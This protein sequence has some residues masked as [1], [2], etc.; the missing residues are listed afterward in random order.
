M[1]DTI[2]F[3]LFALSD[4]RIIGPL[5]MTRAGAR[6]ETLYLDENH[7][8][9]HASTPDGTLEIIPFEEASLPAAGQIV[10]TGRDMTQWIR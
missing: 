8:T 2:R 1:T 7:I 10:S 5:G 6:H 3:V 9:G 4:E